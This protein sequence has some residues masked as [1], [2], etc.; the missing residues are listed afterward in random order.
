MVNLAEGDTAT[1]WFAPM[2]NSAPS[3]VPV[4]GTGPGTLRPD[5]FTV[6]MWV[7]DPVASTSHI[8]S[9]DDGFGG[10]RIDFRQDAEN[11]IDACIQVAP[12]FAGR[13][14]VYGELPDDDQPHYLAFSVE[15]DRIR[16]TV[17]DLDTTT[18]VAD[19][20]S[21]VGSPDLGLGGG[22]GYDHSR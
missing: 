17:D 10:W 9:L 16:L 11:E 21:Y 2:G 5:E 7:Q 15:A 1:R 8:A 22:G 4:S 14:C 20:I 6:E 12:F 13:R 18:L 3:S 19:P